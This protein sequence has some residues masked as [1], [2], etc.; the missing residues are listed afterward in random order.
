M[1]ERDYFFGI[2]G[3]IKSDYLTRIIDHA[4]KSRYKSTDQSKQHDGIMITDQWFQELTKHPFISSMIMI[5]TLVEKPGKAIYLIKERSKLIRVK[6]NHTKHNLGAR[7]SHTDDK[8]EEMKDESQ[9]VPK[10]RKIGEGSYDL[11]YP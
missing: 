9:N 2:L 5:L 10:R 8:S 7:L 6:K 11:V 1:P 4:E 3:S